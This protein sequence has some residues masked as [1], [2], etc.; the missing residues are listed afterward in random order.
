[1][2]TAAAGGLSTRLSFSQANAELKANAK[3]LSSL[4][5]DIVSGFPPDTEALKALEFTELFAVERNVSG[6][7]SVASL[8]FL[9]I[10]ADFDTAGGYR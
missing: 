3:E 7:Y 6:A 4:N 8:A 9:N 2:L 5:N 1:M 10:L